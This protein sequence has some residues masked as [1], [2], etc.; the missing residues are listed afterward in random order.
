MGTSCAAFGGVFSVPGD[1]ILASAEAHLAMAL[2]LEQRNAGA[3]REA[4]GVLPD[5]LQEKLFKR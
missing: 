1:L 3:A 5:E 2:E 4:N